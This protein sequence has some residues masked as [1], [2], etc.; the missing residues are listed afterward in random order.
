MKKHGR[1]GEHAFKNIEKREKILRKTLRTKK[2]MKNLMET[3][4]KNLDRKP[5]IGPCNRRP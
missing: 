2:N 4:I 5:Q 3:L 1:R